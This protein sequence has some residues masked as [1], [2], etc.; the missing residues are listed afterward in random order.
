MSLP[1]LVPE[2]QGTCSVSSSSLLR[3][4]N[5]VL[6]ALQV[7]REVQGPL[8]QGGHGHNHLQTIKCTLV[9][10]EEAGCKW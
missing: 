7:A 2:G 4:R 1:N 8:V 5:A 6:Y 9:G 10:N 3:E